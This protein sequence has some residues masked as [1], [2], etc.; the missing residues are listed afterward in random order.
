MKN[1]KDRSIPLWVRVCL[2]RNDPMGTKT[3]EHLTA[4]GEMLNDK[5][6][7]ARGEACQAL[8]TLGDKASS[9]LQGL[10]DLIGDGKQPTPVVIAGVM[11]LSAMPSQAAKTV[12]IL[13][14][15]QQTHKNE[16]VKRYA[17]EAVRILTT[18]KK[19]PPVAPKM[20]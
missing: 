17:A 12:P 13:T 19:N 7:A 16:E 8:G 10:L 9:Q 15:M 4:I 2:V 18:P 14:G 3:S 20:N 5:L 11:A 6:P 1:D